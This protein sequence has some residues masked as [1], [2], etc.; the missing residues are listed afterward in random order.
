MKIF[1]ASAIAIILST[2]SFSVEESPRI[3][4]QE[5]CEQ[6]ILISEYHLRI[7]NHMNPTNYVNGYWQGQKDAFNSIQ[8]F[9]KQQDSH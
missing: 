1:L 4:L 7:Y 5:F 3:N 9:I 2:N 6:S 8:E